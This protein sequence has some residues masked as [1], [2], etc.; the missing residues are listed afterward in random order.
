[1]PAGRAW[2]DYD[3]EADVLY[4]SL[5]RPQ[6]ATD[7]EY[8][9]NEGILLRYKGKELV[10]VTVLE[11]SKRRKPRTSA[12][13]RSWRLRTRAGSRVGGSAAVPARE[14]APGTYPTGDLRAKRN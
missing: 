9:E 14:K 5:R 10:G 4:I 2:L 12:G 11:A 13:R 6:K 1:L 7:T 8:L 3:R